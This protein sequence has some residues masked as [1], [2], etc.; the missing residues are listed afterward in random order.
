VRAPLIVAV[1]VF[2]TGFLWVWEFGGSGTDCVMAAPEGSSFH[3]EPALWPPGAHRCVV[4][5]A[6]A[7]VDVSWRGWLTVAL[8]AASA[9]FAVAAL[10]RPVRA[11][12]A[13]VLL[14]AAG[15]AYFM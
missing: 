10:R 14:F 3:L 15:P 8:L 1:V 6:T 4:D 9:G 7:Y 11:A 12:I 5:G 13:F 2:V